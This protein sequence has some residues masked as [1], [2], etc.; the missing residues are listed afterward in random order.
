MQ[1]QYC[2][3]FVTGSCPNPFKQGLITCNRFMEEI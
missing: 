2:H 3:H 1:C